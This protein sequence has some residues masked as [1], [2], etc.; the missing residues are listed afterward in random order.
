LDDREQE[1]IQ[2]SIEDAYGDP[3]KLNAAIKQHPM[4]KQAAE[5]AEK[6]SREAAKATLKGNRF[7]NELESELDKVLDANPGVDPEVQK[8]RTKQDGEAQRVPRHPKKPS[9]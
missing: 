7:Y 5:L 4:V 1:V 6:A 2:Q 9:R 3:D 8:Y